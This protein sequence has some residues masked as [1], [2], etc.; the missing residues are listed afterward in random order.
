MPRLHRSKRPRYA[1]P[2]TL[3]LKVCDCCGAR[4]MTMYFPRL[5]GEDRRSDTCSVCLRFP[6]AVSRAA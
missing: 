2:E 3:K 1:N 4:I 5:P 6:S